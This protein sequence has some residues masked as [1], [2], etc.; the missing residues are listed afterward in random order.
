MRHWL[1]GALKANVDGMTAKALCD[2]SSI[3]EL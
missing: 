3:V 1:L 2:Y